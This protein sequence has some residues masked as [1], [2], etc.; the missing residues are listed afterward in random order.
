MS[1]CLVVI[2]AGGHARVLLDVLARLKLP[3]LGIVDSDPKKNQLPSIFGVPV[4]G[5]DDAVLTL[6]PSDIRLVNGLG[7]TGNMSA[8]KHIFDRFKAKGFQFQ[9][10]IDPTAWLGSDV[11]LEEGVQVLAR[12]VLQPGSTLGLNTIV[13]TGSI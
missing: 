11:H 6:D 3:V 8:R 2:G 12:A 4:L 7:S 1:L 10:V 5:S 9:T 13:N